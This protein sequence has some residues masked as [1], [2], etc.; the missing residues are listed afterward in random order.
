[1]LVYLLVEICE[2]YVL[3]LLHCNHITFLFYIAHFCTL[4]Q[5]LIQ[6]LTLARL[7]T[8]NCTKTAE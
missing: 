3:F 7:N 5:F 6:T 8:N 1:M 2:Q 4:T